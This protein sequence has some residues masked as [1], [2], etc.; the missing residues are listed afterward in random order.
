MYT[1]YSLTNQ[2]NGRQYIGMT[3]YPAER[4]FMHEY[5]LGR[6]DH[7]NDWLQA[8]WN[9][10]QRDFEFAA[11]CMVPTKRAAQRA[12]LRWIQSVK[13]PYNIRCGRHLDMKGRICKRFAGSRPY[14]YAEIVAQDA[15]PI[16]DL[17]SRFGCSPALVSMIRHGVRTAPA[18]QTSFADVL[19]ADDVLPGSVPSR[20]RRIYEEA[21]Q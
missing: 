6:G 21:L 9:A 15:V 7:P 14:V 20:C 10:G 18:P 3:R 1:I 19:T 17:V 4:R 11:L 8:D 13:Q 16:G 5:L 12:E 2:A